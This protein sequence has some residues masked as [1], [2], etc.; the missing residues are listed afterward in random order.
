[1][2]HRRATA[3]SLKAG[4]LRGCAWDLRLIP[5]LA[6]ELCQHSQGMVWFWIS[7]EEYTYIKY[8][9]STVPL[10]FCLNGGAALDTEETRSRLFHEPHQMVDP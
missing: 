9:Y 1:M 2:E 5:A 10:Y 4:F 8:S 3:P 6:E 7:P